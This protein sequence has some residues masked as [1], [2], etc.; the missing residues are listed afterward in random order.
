MIVVYLLLAFSS[1]DTDRTLLLFLLI[2]FMCVY[3]PNGIYVQRM[4]AGSAD[5]RRRQWVLWI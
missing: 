5:V 1:L 3:V 2:Y 4:W